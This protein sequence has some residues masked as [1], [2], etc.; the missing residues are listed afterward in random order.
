VPG[1]RST[2]TFCLALLLAAGLVATAGAKVAPSLRLTDTKPVVVKGTGFRP[3]ERIKV[4]GIVDEHRHVRLVRS[5]RTGSF[6]ATFATIVQ[7]DPCTSSFRAYAVGA[8][9]DKA[10]VT[11]GQR[12]CPPSE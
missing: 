2:R 11:V 3:L 1:M 7:L 12:A 4:T 6:V 5:T 8:L 9:G 10:S